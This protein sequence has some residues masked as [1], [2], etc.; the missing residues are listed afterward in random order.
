[1]PI[2]LDI[3]NCSEEG[4]FKAVFD[5]FKSIDDRFSP[6]KPDS[7]LSRLNGGGIDNNK[8]SSEMQH[9]IHACKKAEQ[10]TDGYFSAYHS[11]TLDTNGYVK[12]WATAQ[13]SEL[14]RDKGVDTFCIGAGGDVLAASNSDKIWAVGIQDPSNGGAIIEQIE[15]KNF[16][17][18]TSGTYERGAHIINPKTG[19]PASMFLSLSVIG[20][21]II[22]ADILATAAFAAGKLELISNKKSYKALAVDKDGKILATKEF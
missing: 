13:A 15:G 1:M 21:D 20:P 8:L 18:A 19:K 12:A 9:V 2:S 11:G 6:Y 14:L 17:V 22:Q 3:P 16:A 10:E 5:K 7:E 4:I